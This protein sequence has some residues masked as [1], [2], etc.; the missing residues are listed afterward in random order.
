MAT[1]NESAIDNVLAI[2]L[3]YGGRLA[4]MGFFYRGADIHYYAIMHKYSGPVF[5]AS[6]AER[7]DDVKIIWRFVASI[8]SKAKSL[9]V[10][11]ASQGRQVGDAQLLLMVD[12]RLCA[13]IV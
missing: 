10:H 5:C 3:M 2:S 4:S 1:G 6:A 13:S 8:F 9:H 7:L 12:D 11:R